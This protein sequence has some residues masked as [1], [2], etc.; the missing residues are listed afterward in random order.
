VFF[1]ECQVAPGVPFVVDDITEENEAFTIDNL[2][3]TYD[4]F[5]VTSKGLVTANKNQI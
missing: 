2:P 1:L 4:S 3:K 5:V